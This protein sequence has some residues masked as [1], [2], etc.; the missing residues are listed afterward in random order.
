M[1]NP[2]ERLLEIG[3]L[4]CDRGDYSL[5]LP[6]L[7]EAAKSLLDEKKFQTYLKSLQLILR[8][9]A[10]RAEHEQITSIKE[11]LHDLVIR[12]GIELSSKMYYVLGLCSSLK[13]QPENAIEYLKKALELG[14]KSNNQEDM[15]YAILG[16]SIC[17]RQQGKFEEALK[18]VYNLNIFLQVLNSTEL[19]IASSN[20]NSRILGVN[21]FKA[22][23]KSFNQLS[24]SIVANSKQSLR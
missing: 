5:A 11:H 15:C 19:K 2:S 3:K 20:S 1:S 21:R 8:I 17:Y 24:P 16:L 18:E 14:L 23:N 22:G 10:E 6:N 12:E 4:Y 13:A 9:H 7:Q